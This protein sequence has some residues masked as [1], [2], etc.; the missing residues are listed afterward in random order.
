MRAT[1]SVHSNGVTE[2]TL[3]SDSKEEQR[4][5][6]A[7]RQGANVAIR[8]EYEGHPSNDRVTKV[9]FIQERDYA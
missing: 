7:F 1:A 5:L 6:S 2:V 8:I 4:V 9:R 3:F